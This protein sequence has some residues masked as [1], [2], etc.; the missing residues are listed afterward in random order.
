MCLGVLWTELACSC[1]SGLRAVCKN[2]MAGYLCHFEYTM[3]M[4]YTCR[5]RK[6]VHADGG[7]EI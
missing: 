1:I 4:V 5:G 7:N 2:Q 3:Y 6:Y